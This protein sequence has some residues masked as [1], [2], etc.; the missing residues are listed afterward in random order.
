M[1]PEERKM[2][3]VEFINEH[4]KATVVELCNYFG[5]SSATIRNDL[6]ELERDKLIYRTHG[7]AMLITKTGYELD[8]YIK[9]V[10]NLEEKQKVAKAAI[11][12]IDDGDTIILDTGTT[13]LELAR[14]LDRKRNITVVTNDLIIALF[15]EDFTNVTTI[16]IGGLIRKN[17]HCT[18]TFGEAGKQMLSGLTVDKAFMTANG[19]SYE[20]GATTPDLN[21]AETKKL[22]I[23]IATTSILLCDNSKFGNN[24]LVQFA[25]LEK[26]DKLVTDKIGEIE[27]KALEESDVDVIVGTDF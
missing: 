25:P 11:G 14:L 22:L 13:T 6:H 15:L 16:F 8:P 7:G 17:Y 19:F 2:K 23:S 27:K 21:L 9:Q 12:L 10:K 20:K 4:K 18:L 1:F 3:I 24:F 5:V 26:L